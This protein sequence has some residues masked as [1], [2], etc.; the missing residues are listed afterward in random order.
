ME[1]KDKNLSLKK[2]QLLSEGRFIGYC[3]HSNDS[4]VSQF[5]K[6]RVHIEPAFLRA[7]EQDGFLEPLFVSE[8]PVRE[9]GGSS[10]IQ[11]VHYYSPFQIYT[12]A[13]LAEN[14]I[15]DGKLQSP[16]VSAQWQKEQKARFVSWGYGGGM[17][18][19]V[20]Q[21]QFRKGTDA[22]GRVNQY[23]VCEYLHNF[24]RLLHSQDLPSRYSEITRHERE[25]YYT[26]APKL[27]YNFSSLQGNGRELLVSRGLDE[28]KLEIHFSGE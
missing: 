1:D 28:K 8:E 13:Q 14:E 19:N 17:S 25:R 18:S 15:V 20:D 5:G 6:L 3:N 16:H 24:L 21:P 12:I 22:N 11:P 10:K 26:D 2:E 27:Q 7:A 23:G 9:E 4:R